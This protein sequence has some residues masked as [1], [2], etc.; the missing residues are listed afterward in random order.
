MGFNSEFKGLIRWVWVAHSD[1][2]RNGDYEWYKDNWLTDTLCKLK[3][4]WNTVCVKR[5]VVWTAVSLLYRHGNWL[6]DSY[7]TVSFTR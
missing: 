2:S 7:C 1:K 4:N 6:T 3:A 5:R